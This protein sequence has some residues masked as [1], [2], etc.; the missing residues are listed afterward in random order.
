[1]NIKIIYYYL[2]MSCIICGGEWRR[3]CI[4]CSDYFCC[5]HDGHLYRTNDG[6]LCFNCIYSKYQ[7][8]KTI[9]EHYVKEVKEVE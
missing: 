2:K 3:Q 5:Q 9:V 6:Q 8:Y 7:E 4:S 1:M